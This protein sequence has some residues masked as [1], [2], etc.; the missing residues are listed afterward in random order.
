M[1]CASWGEV[2]YYN[3]ICWLST[4]Q[5]RKLLFLPLYLLVQRFLLLPWHPF[6]QWS[7]PMVSQFSLLMCQKANPMQREWSLLSYASKLNQLTAWP[8]LCQNLCEDKDRA[9]QQEWGEWETG[10]G[11]CFLAPVIHEVGPTVTPNHLP[12]SFNSGVAYF[13]KARPKHVKVIYHFLY[14][15]LKSQSKLKNKDML[16]S[17]ILLLAFWE[18]AFHSTSCFFFSYQQQEWANKNTKQNKGKIFTSLQK[19]EILLAFFFRIKLSIMRPMIKH[20]VYKN[21]LSALHCFPSDE[22]SHMFFG[23]VLIQLHQAEESFTSYHHLARTNAFVE[24]SSKEQG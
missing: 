12:R 24:N 8:A 10:K 14:H 2:S 11:F 13:S 22:A 6:L 9:A 19:P 3:R 4:T 7:A 15:D 23:A 18:C 5:T 16:K 20:I 1:A 17:C 21:A